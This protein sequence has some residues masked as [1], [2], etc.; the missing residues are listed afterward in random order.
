MSA[1]FLIKFFIL[2]SCQVEGV[3][4]VHRDS[5]GYWWYHKKRDAIN[6]VAANALDVKNLQAARRDNSQ[7]DRSGHEARSAGTFNLDRQPLT[8]WYKGT[9]NWSVTDEDYVVSPTSS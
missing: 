9:Y 3:E 8:D 4:L 7:D 1:Q 5:K 2:Q 6:A